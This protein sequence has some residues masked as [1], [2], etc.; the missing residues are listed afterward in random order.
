M[1]SVAVLPHTLLHLTSW[2]T[3]TFGLLARAEAEATPASQLTVLCGRSTD[4][5][6][7][8][9]GPVRGRQPGPQARQREHIHNLG[10][11][12]HDLARKRLGNGV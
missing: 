9:A 1:A 5:G 8:H 3:T 2:S 12:S 11:S 7:G 6:P 4:V 10:G